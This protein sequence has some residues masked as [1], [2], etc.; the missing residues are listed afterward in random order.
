MYLDLSEE[1]KERRRDGRLTIILLLGFLLILSNIGSHINQSTQF[2]SRNNKMLSVTSKKQ[3]YLEEDM[4]ITSN[5]V[6]LPLSYFPF[7]FLPLP[8]NLADKELLMTIK[9]IGPVLAETIVAHRQQVGEIQNVEDFQTIPG[10]GKNRAMS[11]TT[12]LVFDKTE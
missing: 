7:S 2:S 1:E 10:I 3:L 5:P 12:E 6:S 11:L 8:I 4:R 9:G